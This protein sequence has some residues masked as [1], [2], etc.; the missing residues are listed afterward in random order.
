[1]QDQGKILTLILLFIFHLLIKSL[2]HIIFP[3]RAGLKKWVL[4]MRNFLKVI[5]GNSYIHST[6]TLNLLNPAIQ[7]R[8][9]WCK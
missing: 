8:D 6:G 2:V 3:K 1:M 7:A 9:S 5:S 4:K